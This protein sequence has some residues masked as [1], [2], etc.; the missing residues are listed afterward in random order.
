MLMLPSNAVSQ[1]LK[2][3]APCLGGHSIDQHFALNAYSA[4]QG[5]TGPYRA[6]QV[7]T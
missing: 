4:L 7:L 5:F 1:R 6:L 3:S 2:F